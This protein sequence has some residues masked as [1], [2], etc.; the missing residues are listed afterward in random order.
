MSLP[1]YP[2]DS[3]LLLLQAV[4]VVSVGF[5]LLRLTPQERTTAQQC[6]QVLVRRPHPA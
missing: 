4:G 5:G 1:T 6:R 3:M 2:L